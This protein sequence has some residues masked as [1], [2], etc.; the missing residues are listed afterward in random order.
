MKEEW[1]AIRR[2]IRNLEKSTSSSLAYRS[3]L[4]GILRESLPFDGACFTTVDPQTLLCTGAVTEEGIEAIHHLLFEYEYL[5]EDINAYSQLVLAADPVATLSGATN[6]QLERSTRYRN[7]LLPA[8][9]KDELRAALMYQ[10]ACWGYLTLF[11]YDDR[12]LFSENERGCIAS[13]VPTIAF[14]LRQRSLELPSEETIQMK[15]ESGLVIL[16]DHLAMLSSNTV[17][18]RWMAHLRQWEGIDNETLPRPIR[19]VSFRALSGVADAEERGFTAKVRIRTPE[20]PYL[21]IQASILRHTSSSVQ[22]AIWFEQ[23]KPSDT[24]P[25]IAEA[26]GLSERE[27]QILDQILRGSST[28][29]LANALHIST[30]TVQDHLKSIFL[31]TGVTSRRELIWLLFSRFSLR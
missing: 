28:K 2:K 21:S 25:L 31:K 13:L 30:Y 17:G 20:G 1:E 27:K 19:A 10:G 7:V 24:L 9:Y 22:I 11:R 3:A 26:Y 16:S 29:E 14:H 5:H 23:A 12:P 18:D 15:E 6:G 4:L 8:G